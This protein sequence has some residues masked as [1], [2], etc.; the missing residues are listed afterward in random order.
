MPINARRFNTVRLAAAFAVI[1]IL[2]A[3]AHAQPSP[4]P[5]QP[6]AKLTIIGSG[7]LFPLINDV[8]RRFERLH[9]GVFI[10]VRAGGSTQGLADLRAGV[11]DIAML[12]RA[13][14]PDERD[15]FA[16]PIVRDGVAVLVNR[17]NPVT[18][19]DT[20]QLA[21]ILTGKVVNWKSVGG[22][23]APVNF[24][25]RSKGKGTT[26][27]ILE[28]LKL[29]R[30]QL[31]PSTSIVPSN[32]EAIRF[33]AADP[34]AISLGSVAAANLSANAGVAIKQL[35]INGVQPSKK[36]IGNNTYV[37]SRP[38]TLITR[39]APQGLQ[40]KFIDYALS[41]PVVDLHTQHGFVPYRE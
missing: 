3:V 9:A 8:A 24:G 13:P 2:A 5:Q 11:A 6:Q 35:A 4:K 18:N 29:K 40:K 34:N 20:G 16:F 37:L 25:W 36:T 10:D 23:D 1:T 22:R 15:L 26:E 31:R 17:E 41:R 12:S 14:L 38:L 30:E 21:A 19:L 28:H 33:V 27:F 7:T 32:S 39:S